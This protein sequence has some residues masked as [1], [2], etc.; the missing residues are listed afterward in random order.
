M[1]TKEVAEALGVRPQN[2]QFVRGLPKPVG[3]IAASRL[4]LGSEVR[5]FAER[6]QAARVIRI[7][8]EKGAVE[9]GD[10]MTLEA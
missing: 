2:I 6:R 4:W 1:G 7:C 8:R 10:L 9:R 3:Q 5:E